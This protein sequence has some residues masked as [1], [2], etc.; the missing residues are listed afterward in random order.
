MAFLI[1]GRVTHPIPNDLVLQ[2]TDAYLAYVKH[3]KAE[4]AVDQVWNYTGCVGGC[5]IV[6]LDSV[7][8]LDRMLMEHPFL[9]FMDISTEPLVEAEAGSERFKDVFRTMMAA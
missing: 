4:G 6:N 3:W 5:M 2:L 1:H 9:P 7:A 8:E